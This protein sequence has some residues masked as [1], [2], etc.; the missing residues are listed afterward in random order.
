MPYYATITLQGHTEKDKTTMTF[1][2][3]SPADH[4]DALDALDQIRGSLVDI[5][6]AYLRRI[7]LSEVVFDDNQRP[8]DTSADTFEEA[9]VS[10]YLNVSTDAEKLHTLRVPA[11]IEALFLSDA[12]TVNPSNA[13][14]IQ[15]VQQVA[16]HSFVSD[17]ETIKTSNNN[18]IKGGSKRSR[19]RNFK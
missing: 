18:G 6:K 5:T 12:S 2:L 8:S 11:P 4:D 10:T 3:G 13:L 16:Q 9:A 14:L 1:D 15:Y 7:V 19:A 17:G